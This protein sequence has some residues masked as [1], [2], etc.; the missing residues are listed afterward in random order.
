MKNVIFSIIV[1]LFST[2]LAL[3]V[4][5]AVVRVKNSSMQN[6]DIEM[7]RYAKELK[8]R[9]ADPVLGHEHVPSKSAVLQSVEIRI[10]RATP[11]SSAPLPH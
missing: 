8:Q 9:S 2:L 1:C 5:E 3:G 4:G 10:K 11:N 6:Y 7:W